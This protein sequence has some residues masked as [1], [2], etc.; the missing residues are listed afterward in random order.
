MKFGSPASP[1]RDGRNS[2]LY[3]SSLAGLYVWVGRVPTLKTLGYY[4]VS[5]R[6]KVDKLLG[7]SSGEILVALPGMGTLRGAWHAGPSLL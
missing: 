7:L 2:V 4:R 6:D 5:L 3:Q 1:A